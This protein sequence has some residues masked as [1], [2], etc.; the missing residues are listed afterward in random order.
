MKKTFKLLILLMLLPLLLMPTNSV[1]AQGPGPDEDGKV[2]FGSN[3]TLESGD[4]F[5]GDLVLLGGNV[6]IE[7]DAILNG[8]LVVM[9]GTITSSGEITGSI[10]VMGG[11][12][13]LEETARVAGDVV[14][15]GGQ[16]NQEEGAEIGGDVVNNVAPDFTFP[17]GKIPPTAP[18]AN[19][20]SIVFPNVIDNFNPIG[21]AWWIFVRAFLL[22]AFAMFVSLF[23]QPQI[24]RTGQ[25]IVTQ[26]FMAG[27]IGLASA[28]VAAALFLTFVP[29]VL[30]ALAWVFG[31]VAMGREVGERFA[32][33]VNQVWS[34]VLSIGFGTFLLALA[35]GAIGLIP[36][37]GGLLLF[38]FGLVGVGASVIT[39]FGTRPIQ[40]PALS[41]Y[42]PP[43]GSS[44]P[45]APVG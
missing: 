45:E 13:S 34:P 9:G 8:D 19:A 28:A 17:I 31:V 14:T 15:I 29:L 30:L 2:I 44:G 11:Q 24:E 37:L 18:D 7:E 42:A 33:A 21:E 41:V 16:V 6:T 22:G 12:V 5:D 23:L 27:A 38:L 36:C 26:P 32:K 40:V 39:L 3:Y 4:T 10:V 43:P 20:P 25:A 35:G 1:Q